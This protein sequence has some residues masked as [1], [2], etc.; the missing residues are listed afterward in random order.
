M[1]NYTH[2][3]FYIIQTICKTHISYNKCSYRTQILHKKE[4][5]IHSIKNSNSNWF[6]KKHTQLASIFTNIKTQ[7]LVLNY[8]MKSQVCYL[9]LDTITHPLSHIP[10]AVVANLPAKFFCHSFQVQPFFFLC[11]AELHTAHN[12]IIPHKKRISMRIN[13]RINKNCEDLQC[14]HKL[15]YYIL[16]RINT[17]NPPHK[18]RILNA[19]QK[20]D[21]HYFIALAICNRICSP[22]NIRIYHF[23][24]A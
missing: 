16:S 18:L 4:I 9:H 10:V 1:V 19:S 5:K 24:G 2:K 23:P 6:Q 17:L 20:K 13:I 14:V 15:T 22:H 8:S 7:H 21:A 11:C 3:Q 12:F